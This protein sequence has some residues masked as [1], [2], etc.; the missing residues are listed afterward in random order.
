MSLKAVSGTLATANDTVKIGCQGDNLTYFLLKGT[1]TGATVVVEATLDGTNWF[2]INFNN[3]K[4]TEAYSIAQALTNSSTVALYTVNSVFSSIRI[5]VTAI[6]TGSISVVAVQSKGFNDYIEDCLLVPT[7]TNV[8][9]LT[10]TV[11][12]GTTT[13]DQPVVTT[14]PGVLHRFVVTTVGSAAISFYDDPAVIS[15]KPL[16]Y[17]SGTSTP[18]VG[19]VTELNMYFKNGITASQASGTA[20]ITF[21]YSLI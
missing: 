4:N 9:K 10:A 20:A 6:S 7:M 17:T 15:G 18:A 16:L 19:T 2:T 12:A 8:A 14:G 13:T 21:M 1:Y 11:P 5:R 3:V